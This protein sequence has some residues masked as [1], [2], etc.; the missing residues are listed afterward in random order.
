VKTG[1]L[2]VC[3]GNICRSPLA[4]M[5]FAAHAEKRGVSDLLEIDSCGTGHWHVG[6]GADYRSVEIARQRGLTLPHCA[7]QLDPGSD[8]RRFHWLIA[9]DRENRAN[10]ISAGAARERVYLMRSFD[11]AMRGLPEHE[12]DVPDPYYGHGDGFA[13][14]YD[15]LAAASDGLLEAVLSSR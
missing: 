4:R 11:P 9:M 1:V 13:R 15:M 7:R 3:L 10:V 8:F 14:V 12:L 5:I 2:F 6:K